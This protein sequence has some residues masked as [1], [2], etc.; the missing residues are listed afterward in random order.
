MVQV[1]WMLSKLETIVFFR[2]SH[3]MYSRL[4]RRR[5]FF[6]FKDMVYS[7]LREVTVIEIENLLAN[8]GISEGSDLPAPEVRH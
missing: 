4:E 3:S 1:R 6:Q 7:M 5:I 8:E 2:P